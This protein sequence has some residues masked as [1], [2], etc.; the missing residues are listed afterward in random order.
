MIGLLG[1]M[2]GCDDSPPPVVE[3]PVEVAPPTP[4]ASITPS[5]PPEPEAPAEAAVL[6]LRTVGTRMVFEQTALSAP[7][8]PIRLTYTSASTEPAMLHNVVIVAAGTEDAVGIAGID[9]GPD[10]AYVPEHDAVLASSPLLS[11][12]ESA[13]LLVTLQPGTYAYTCT[14]PGH[15]L[16]ERG[17]LTVKAP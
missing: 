13:E 8:G 17:V 6:S 7:A 14:F 16:T 11:P 4:P 12:E 3:A 5:L 10:R 15:Y 1:V 9:A 2:L